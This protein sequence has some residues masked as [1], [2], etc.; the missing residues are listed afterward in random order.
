MTSPVRGLPSARRLRSTDA[1]QGVSV[2]RTFLRGVPSSPDPL[3]AAGCRGVESEGL[4]LPPRL[5]L[6]GGGFTSTAEDASAVFHG[7]RHPWRLS[8][9]RIRLN[10]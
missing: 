10:D 5:T 7:L 9:R 2:E 8:Q 4:S 6:L 1:T 3:L